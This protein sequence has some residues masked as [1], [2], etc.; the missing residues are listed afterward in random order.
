MDVVVIYKQDDTIQCH[1]EVP[2]RALS[3]DEARLRRIG[4]QTICASGNVPGPVY[5]SR[6]CGA[7]T[8]QVN[9]LAISEADWRALESGIAG[10]LGFK[11]WV[12]APLPQLDWTEECSFGVGPVPRSVMMSMSV[13]PFLIR[14][15]FGRPARCYTQGDPLT[16]DFVPERVNIEKDKDGAILNIWFG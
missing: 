9:A 4:V 8:S 10:T 16:D 14:D 13:L 15:L 3:D 6:V 7:P 11:L 1:P 2:P 12:G 5:V